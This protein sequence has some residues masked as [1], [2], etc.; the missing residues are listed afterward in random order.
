MAEKG[1][2]ASMSVD[3]ARVERKYKTPRPRPMLQERSEYRPATCGASP[4]RALRSRDARGR[5]ERQAAGKRNSTLNAR[6]LRALSETADG[7]ARLSVTT[8][9]RFGSNLWSS[10]AAGRSEEHTSE[11]QSQSNLVC[12]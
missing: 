3:A 12:R 11:L 10:D 5:I 7:C 9:C 6:W 4:P 2:P 1:S 8:F